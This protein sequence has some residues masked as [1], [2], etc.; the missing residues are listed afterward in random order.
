MTT[1]QRITTTS[2]EETQALAEMLGSALIP[3]SILRLDGPLGAGK[4]CF[5]QGLARGLGVPPQV[6]VHSPT[7]TLLNIYPGRLPLYHFDWYRLQ[8][9]QELAGLDIEEYFDGPGV[10]VVE[11]GGKFPHTFPPHTCIL[12]FTVLSEAAREIIISPPSP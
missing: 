3:G 5:V 1:T 11:W 7:F 4:T 9:V 12:T 2:P 8:Q 6:R 10:S